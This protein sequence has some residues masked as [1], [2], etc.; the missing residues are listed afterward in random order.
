MY[1]T[2][3]YCCRCILG[4]LN[5]KN[6]LKVIK[7]NIAYIFACRIELLWSTAVACVMSILAFVQIIKI[8]PLFPFF[9]ME[10]MENTIKH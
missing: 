10:C 1:F 5:C 7:S 8:L 3:I 9:V 4:D 2:I 6:C